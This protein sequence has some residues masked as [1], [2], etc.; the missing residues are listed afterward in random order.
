MPEDN[1]AR[2][3]YLVVADISGYTAFLTG[4]ELDQA[5]EIMIAAPSR[6]ARV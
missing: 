4:T 2:Q 1:R 3:G 6:R 5:H